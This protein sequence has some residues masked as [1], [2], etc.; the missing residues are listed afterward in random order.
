[1]HRYYVSFAYQSP[2]GFAIGTLDVTTEQRIST[3]EDLAPVT[4]DLTGRDYRN[5]VIMAFSLY[6]NPRRDDNPNRD[7]RRPANP[8]PNRD[9][10][11]DPN[12]NP[13]R[14]PSSRG[15]WS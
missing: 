12:L 6:A 3:V 5:V 13:S 14:K 4:A 10:R 8:T 7:T 11:R 9:A 1:M 15:R 2:N